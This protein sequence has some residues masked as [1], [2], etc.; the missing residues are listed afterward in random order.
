MANR[1]GIISD[2][3]LTSCSVQ[4]SR[5]VELAFRDCTRIIH[6]GDITDLGVLEAFSDKSL[7]AVHGNMCSR[8]VRERFPES[9]RVSIDGYT[10]AVCHGAGLRGSIEERLYE[11]FFDADCIVY[12]HTHQ[13]ANHHYGKT[14]LVNPGSFSGTGRFGN[15]GTYGILET[16]EDTL[17]A[18]I[19]TLPG[20]T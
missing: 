19:H 14:L 17:R 10:I 9:L 13:P 1:I 15:P 6:A 2:T 7:Y 11:R 16:S 12:G 3:H 8:R 18:T 5:L 20:K 4:F